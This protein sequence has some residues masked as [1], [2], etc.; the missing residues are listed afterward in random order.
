[1]VCRGGRLGGGLV[2]MR[3]EVTGWK[4]VER[5]WKEGELTALW[6]MWNSACHFE[7]CACLIGCVLRFHKM[8]LRKVA[9]N[10]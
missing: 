1:V 5:R 6:E 3:V 2:W 9:I 10:L 8:R 7:R 4:G